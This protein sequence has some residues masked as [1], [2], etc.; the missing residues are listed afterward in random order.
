[1]LKI[2]LIG[3]GKISDSHAEQIRRIPDCEIISVCEKE[4]LMAKQF[5]NRFQVKYYFTDVRE[6]LGTMRP[7]VVHI[8]TPP[9]SHFE[10][11][12]ACIEE[13]CHVYIEKPFTVN[14]KEAECLI[15][16]AKERNLKIIPGHDDQFTH[17][18]RRM[19]DSIDEGY[20]GG[21][22][23]HM[24]SYYC[25]DLGEQSYAN[26][27]LGEKSH[28]VR[29]LPGKLLQNIISH[30]ICR[31]VE[32]IRGDH[33]LVI[34]HAFTSKFLIQIGE[35]EIID[36]LRVIIKD[37]YDTTAYFTFSSQMRPLLHHFR[38]FGPKNA[39]AV[40]HDHQTLIMLRGLKYKSYLDKFIPPWNFG[41][42]FMKNSACNINL[43]LKRD[44]H[45]KS[46]MKFL[47]ESFYRSIREDAPLPI[48]NRETIMTARIM[49]EIFSQIYPKI[50]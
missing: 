23:V 29:N 30:G 43:F 21:H 8:T 37:E 46:G 17:S 27:L 6:F 31:I 12:K 25:Y 47:I 4:E 38:V 48:S 36:E 26:A 49:D 24:E 28:W 14:A 3:C 5:C 50:K 18:T 41:L 2:G 34:A 32:Y 33:P 45:M 35:D 19:R 7:D 1:M 16:L 39:L 40:D 15:G 20:L 44:F 13:G 9:Q 22:P 42:Q 10:L 11:G